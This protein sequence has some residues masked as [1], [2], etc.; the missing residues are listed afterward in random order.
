MNHNMNV[1]FYTVSDVS[2]QKGGTER[3]TNTICT[4]LSYKL[5]VNCYLAYKTDLDIKYR[6]SNIFK[7]KI[8]I[9]ES[10]TIHI[11][12]QFLQENQISAIVVQG[13]YTIIPNFRKAIQIYKLNS[14]LIFVHHFNPGAEICFNNLSQKIIELKN[15]KGKNRIIK[16]IKL[17]Q[18]PI[19]ILYYNIYVKYY[20]KKTYLLS[21]SIVLLSEKFIKGWSK[22]TGIKNT[23]KYEIIPNALSF[24]EY[25]DMNEFNK[26]T[27]EVLIISR[28]S[29]Y[30]KRIFL[31]L[32]IWA[33]IKTDQQLK[34]WKLRIIGDGI[35]KNEYIKYTQKNNIQDVIFEGLKTDV[36]NYYKKGA[37]F[38]MTS[39]FEGWGLTITEAQQMGVIP[40][41]FNSYS[42]LSD[43]IYDGVNGFIIPNNDIKTFVKKAKSLMNDNEKRYEMAQNCIETSKRFAI[44][45]I[46][47]KW[48]NLLSK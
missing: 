3:I 17:I 13:S 32:K 21:D 36:I 33:K 23:A 41:A 12:K 22:I 30:Q 40:I 1:L 42:S 14:K 39:R 19:T 46:A 34:N 11:I 35:F 9:N 47:L 16:L 26:K 37:I 15:S 45:K 8:N 31:A 24:E 20:Y 18:L 5:G 44:E 38:F 28:L 27:K 7:K 10:T 48:Y 25:F 4:Y 6:P 29:E 2:P 43:I